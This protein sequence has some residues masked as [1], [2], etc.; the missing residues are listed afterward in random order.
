MLSS[1]AV[2]DRY[3]FAILLAIIRFTTRLGTS[4]CISSHVF[5]NVTKVYKILFFLQSSQVDQY[6]SGNLESREENH[7]Q[8]F[9][10]FTTL[11]QSKSAWNCNV[12]IHVSYSWLW[13]RD[14]KKLDIHPGIF[15]KYLHAHNHYFHQIAVSKLSIK[16]YIAQNILWIFHR[17]IEG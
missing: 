10:F 12:L 6:T 7:N 3:H 11:R 14:A 5:N 16:N 8:I 13:L 2:M 1:T 15:T 4:S 17:K 9:L